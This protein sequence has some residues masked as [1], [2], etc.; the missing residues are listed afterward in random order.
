MSDY[1]ELRASAEYAAL[2]TVASRLGR[3]ETQIQ[4]P[5]GNV[6][7]KSGGRMWVKASGTWLADAETSEVMVPVDAEAMRA[8]L[9]SGDPKADQP[10]SFVP[11]GVE[12]SGLRPSIETSFHAALPAPVVIHT[13]C[14]ATIAAAVQRGA[15]A[16]VRRQLDDLGIVWVP[17]AKP[18]A[19]VARLLLDAWH[20]G[21][22]GAVLG[23]HGLIATGPTAAEAETLLH[24]VSRRLETHAP[25]SAAPA[26]DF[27]EPGWISLGAGP[28]T[29]LAFDQERLSMAKGLGLYPDHVIFLGPRVAVAEPGESLD[30]AADRAAAGGPPC[31]LVLVK[32]QGA[33]IRENATPA[34]RA[35]AEM[36]GAVVGRLPDSAD[37]VRL[38]EHETAEL[39]GWD[40]EKHRQ[41]LER[42]RMARL[43]GDIPDGG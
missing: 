1:S 13:H 36:L 7:L 28:T 38:T 32:R 9:V 21:A 34:V 18:G 15:E 26:G 27:A 3:D 19:A 10:Q 25:P 37:L 23:N 35:L 31:G 30:D 5:G 40:A 14:V 29:A 33:A 39:L 2:L 16:E 22:A 17:Y 20:D 6:S 43:T 8:A 42:E 11:D 12:T 24:D 41:A 4:G